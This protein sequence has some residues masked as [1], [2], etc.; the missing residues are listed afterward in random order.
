M[1]REVFG[2][3]QRSGP[4]ADKKMPAVCRDRR[5]GVFRCR[6]CRDR[7]GHPTEL[8]SEFHSMRAN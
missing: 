2:W 8:S 4:K 6:P 1:N 5:A 7:P 3:A